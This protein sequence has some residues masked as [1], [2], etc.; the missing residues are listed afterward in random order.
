MCPSFFLHVHVNVWLFYFS[1]FACE[2]CSTIADISS[3]C[4]CACMCF[5]FT[6]HIF[7]TFST[8]A[9]VITRLSSGPPLMPF[10]HVRV[11]YA[12][13]YVVAGAGAGVLSQHSPCLQHGGLARHRHVARPPR[14]TVVGGQAAAHDA[15]AVPHHLLWPVERDGET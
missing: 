4:V 6:C 12:Q 7:S 8:P 13:H 1:M 9:C 11:F 2:S 15:G 10:P 14:L 3:V 5:P